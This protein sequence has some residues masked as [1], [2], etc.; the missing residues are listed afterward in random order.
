MSHS[1]LGMRVQEKFVHFIMFRGV[2]VPFFGSLLCWHIPLYC[3]HVILY[4][5]V[6][7]YIGLEYSN[8]NENNKEQKIEYSLILEFLSITSAH[9]FE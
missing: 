7:C 4:Q 3:N 8:D 6:L 1:M 9:N 5:V 2:F